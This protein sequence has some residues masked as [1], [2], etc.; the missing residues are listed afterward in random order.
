MCVCVYS[1]VFCRSQLAHD[2]FRSG[3]KQYLCHSDFSDA[4]NV[5][6]DPGDPQILKTGRAILQ[7]VD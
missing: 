3:A 2:D 1:L 6:K 4:I 5:P 7:C